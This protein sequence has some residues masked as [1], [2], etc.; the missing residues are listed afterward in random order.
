MH[1]SINQSI[2]ESMIMVIII[3]IFKRTSDPRR[4]TVELYTF[5][6]ISFTYWTHNDL[7]LW[8]HDLENLVSNAHIRCKH[9]RQ[10][11]LKF[12]Q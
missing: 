6:I 5:A 1:Q 12:L 3:I 11:S 4:H 7:D 8:P 10:V 9:L 2:T